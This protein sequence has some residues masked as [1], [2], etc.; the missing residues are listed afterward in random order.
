M[1]LV[2]R[3]ERGSIWKQREQQTGIA[4][5]WI[6]MS[7]I[8]VIALVRNGQIWEFFEGGTNMTC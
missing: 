2:A 1:I 3:W 6:R 7:R 8:V 4:V 5:M